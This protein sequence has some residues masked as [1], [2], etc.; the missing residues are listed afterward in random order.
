MVTRFVEIKRHSDGSEHRYNCE[1][2]HLQSRVAVVLF[3]HWSERSS[4]GFLFPPGGRTY[5]F[6]WPRR[7]YSLYRMTGPDG[8][9]IAHRFDVLENCRLSPTGVSYLDLLFDVW[10]GADGVVQVEDEDDVTAWAA[11]GLISPL[12]TRRIA[13]TGALIER[14]HPRIIR[15]AA[16]L[17][18]GR[19][20]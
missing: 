5:G 11:A 20:S 14:D 2:Q 6:F 16:Q 4:G 13:E 1:L 9:L 18:R 8:Q 10:V 12:Q 19:R 3:R 7:A 15:E 17:L